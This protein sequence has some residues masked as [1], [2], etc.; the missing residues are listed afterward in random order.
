MEAR[1]PRIVIRGGIGGRRPQERLLLEL[2]AALID[3]GADLRCAASRPILGATPDD[4][5]TIL[6]AGKAD[7][8]SIP[9]AHCLS[10][11]PFPPPRATAAHRVWLPWRPR[12]KLDDEETELWIAADDEA[13]PGPNVQPLPAGINPVRFNPGA[14]P[15]P[16]PLPHESFKFLYRGPLHGAA[17]A[18]LRA[19][20]ADVAREHACFLIVNDYGF[21]ADETIAPETRGS[22][23][24]FI[25]D[26][27][28]DERHLAGLY[29]ACDCLLASAP[30]TGWTAYEALAC[31]LPVLADRGYEIGGETLPPELV[32]HDCS[33]QSFAG[34]MGRMI[35]EHEHWRRRTAEIGRRVRT[36]M[37]WHQVARGFLPARGKELRAQGASS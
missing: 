1:P 37:S 19:G 13:A 26:K 3:Q 16:L 10:N 32:L 28:A 24:I 18:S 36:G 20:F 29:T 6:L 7:A 5:R 17:F 21:E 35:R 14:A 12:T 27:V 9:A 8:D 11:E 22:P 31:D 25:A 23:R 30:A 15:L 34:A 33:A 4:P 2:G